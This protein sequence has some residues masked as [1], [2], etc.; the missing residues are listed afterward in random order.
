M[1]VS[2]LGRDDVEIETTEALSSGFLKLSR[3]KLRHRLFN[4]GYSHSLERESIVRPPSVGVLLYDPVLDSVALVEQF[5]IGPYLADDDPWLLEVV[6]G[7]SEPGE[8]IEDVAYREVEEEANCKVKKLIP[9]IDFY[10]SPGASNEK[11]KLYCGII[12]ASHAEG[13]FGL[14]EE[15]EDIK[16]HVLPFEKAYQMVEDGNIANAPAVIAIQW[17]KLHHGE[18][19]S[20]A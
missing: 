4:G 6:A 5:R 19:Q 7:I 9:L 11:L 20:Y 12:D 15:G 1:K 18:L 2:G 16:V 8:N 13:V 14:D 3:Y 10:M 17:L